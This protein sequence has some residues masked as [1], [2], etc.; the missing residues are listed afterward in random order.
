MT[1]A[2][3]IALRERLSREHTRR[4]TDADLPARLMALSSELRAAYD[5]RP[6]GPKEWDAVT[7]D[8]D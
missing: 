4:A 8:E 2:V 1:E 3:T 6:V 7:G 5:T